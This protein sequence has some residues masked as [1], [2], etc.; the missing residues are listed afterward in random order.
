M[1]RLRLAVVAA[2]LFNLVPTLLMDVIPNYDRQTHLFMADHYLHHWF[3]D[4]EPRWFGGFCMFSY[5]PLAHQLVAFLGRVTGLENA[6][7]CVQLL[8]LVAM[9]VAM[10]AL[11]EEMLDGETAGHAALLTAVA[12]GTSLVAYAFGMLPTILAFA[13]A[14]G[15]TAALMRYLR[16]G[17]RAMLVAWS[18]LG[19]ATMAAHHLT[20]ILCVPALTVAAVAAH[21]GR[22]RWRDGMRVVMALACLALSGT[23]VILPFWWWLLT[24]SVPQA[25]IPH[26]TRSS[27]F[28]DADMA[29]R[30]LLGLGGRLAVPGSGGIVDGPARCAHPDPGCDHRAAGP[31]GPGWHHG[32]AALVLPGLVEMADV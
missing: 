4:W 20:C 6:Y 17:D 23:L 5:P 7:A 22:S 10:G 24:M 25:E 31:A 27:L 28:N 21:V 29:R 19:A 12:S 3:D 32:A 18:A 26:Y 15:A 9:P 16:R 30:Y 2:L 13:L 11:A 14:L 8:T 1:S